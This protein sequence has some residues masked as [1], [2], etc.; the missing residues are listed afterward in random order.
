MSA[1]REANRAM[2]NVQIIPFS[3]VP[4]SVRLT[5]HTTKKITGHVEMSVLRVQSYV[6][7]NVEAITFSVVPIPV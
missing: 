3:V 2:V 7:V 1:L 5:T 4:T 6:M